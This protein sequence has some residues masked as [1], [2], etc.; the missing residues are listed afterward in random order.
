MSERGWRKR[1]L[2]LLTRKGV[3]RRLKNADVAHDD[4]QGDQDENQDE[5]EDDDEG[6]GAHL[7]RG[8]AGRDF[9]VFDGLHGSIVTQILMGGATRGRG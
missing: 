5:R 8:E 6:G 3:R 1:K 2:G 7:A 4:D 9:F